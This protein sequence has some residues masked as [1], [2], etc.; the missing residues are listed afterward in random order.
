[1]RRIK[2][3]DLFNINSL[4][5]PQYNS[6]GSQ[7]IY[8]ENH[9]NKIDDKYTSYIHLYDLNS[10]VDLKLI[11]NNSLNFE[12]KW[13]D[14]DKSFLF[15]SNISGRNQIYKFDLSKNKIFQMTQLNSKEQIVD[16]VIS[17]NE[18]YLV[19]ICQEDS[20]SE[21]EQIAYETTRLFY[22]SNGRGLLTKNGKENNVYIKCL[23]KKIFFR[24]GRS[25]LGY[26]LRKA[27][28]ITPDSRS[29]FIEELIDPYNDLKTDTGLY[30]YHLNENFDSIVSR[31]SFTKQLASVGMFG[32]MAFSDNYRYIGF[33][34]STLPYRTSNQI[35]LYIYDTQLDNF[36]NLLEDVDVQVTDFCVTDFHQNNTNTQLK[37]NETT[38]SFIFLVSQEGNVCLFS[39]NPKS[40]EVKRLTNIHG[41]IQDFSINRKKNKAILVISTPSL[42]ATLQELDLDTKECRSLNV[43]V[44]KL[45]DNYDFANYQ[46]FEF[47]HPDGGRIPCFLVLPQN[48]KEN[49]KFP[50]ILNIHGGPYTMHGYTF[51]HEIQVMAASGFAV[52]L[53]NPR[54]SI[55]YGQHHL[56][57]VVGKYGE[58]DYEDLMIAVDGILS[59]CPY[60]DRDNLF[61][62]GGSYG[63]FMTNWIV[64]KTARFKR[65]ATQRSMTNFVS[66][67]GTSDIGASFFS[68][69]NAGSDIL[70]PQKLWQKSPLAY[71][72]N[73]KTPMLIIQSDH[74]LRC[75]LEQAE[76]WFVA[77]RYNHVSAKFIKIFN[78]NHELSRS[79]TPSK[80]IF[81]LQQIMDCFM[82]SD[83]FSS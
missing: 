12:P 53:V 14:S 54:G 36:V 15:I 76:Q 3:D 38:E 77:L 6:T 41:H 39:A 33:L 82:K 35:K 46:K 79:G 5:A 19:L 48:Y 44:K 22:Q 70:N 51:N 24:I 56:D 20:I 64:T 28:S 31:K 21:N 60:I 43:P 61:V 25:Y 2:I 18:E 26:G 7:L 13:F 65:A 47:S 71:V 58:K 1:M 30:E 11:D 73:V 10:N 74:D 57:G 78:E 66:M 34:G 23:N 45:N 62:T 83:Y 27:V 75:P 40:L 16:F 55:G 29:I 49:H 52:L 9:I 80:R 67:F 37:W 68:E 17:P 69:E 32:E 63:G 8:V 50:L 72:K 4:A 81:R 59:K 42:P